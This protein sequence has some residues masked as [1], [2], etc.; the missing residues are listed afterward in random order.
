M[1][2][3]GCGGAEKRKGIPDGGNSIRQGAEVCARGKRELASFREKM[4]SDLKTMM[5]NVLG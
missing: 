1:G 3:G 5:G 2:V 4:P